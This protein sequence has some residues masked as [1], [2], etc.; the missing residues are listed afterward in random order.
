VRGRL[1]AAFL[2]ALVLTTV[3]GWVNLLGARIFWFVGAG[4]VMAMLAA[5]AVW[6][7][8]RHF[9]DLQALMRERFWAREAGQHHAFGSVIIKICDD[10]RFVWMDGQALLR[11]LGRRE[12]EDALAARHAGYWRRTEKGVLMLRV[13]AVVQHLAR[14]PGRDEPR[15]QKLRHYL[16]RDVLYPAERRRQTR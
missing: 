4:V 3:L 6:Y 9:A 12:P 13:D 2:V 16:E 5:A 15:I 7:G 10:G 14:M 8:A 11:V 1:G